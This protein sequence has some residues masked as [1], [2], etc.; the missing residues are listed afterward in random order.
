MTITAQWNSRTGLTVKG[1]HKA[2]QPRRWRLEVKATYL[3]PAPAGLILDGEDVAEGAW[4]RRSESWIRPTSNR[5][6]L[7]SALGEQV[8]AELMEKMHEGEVLE[9]AEFVAFG[10]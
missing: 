7:L 5:P 10:R 8:E 9:Y 1:T 4:L 3:F 6:Y 2:S